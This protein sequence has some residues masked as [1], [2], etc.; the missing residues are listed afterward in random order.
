MS[1]LADEPVEDAP[2]TRIPVATD[3]LVCSGVS[4]A[5]AGVRALDQVNFSGP[6][7]PVRRPF[8]TCSP[9]SRE[10]SQARSIST[11]VTS[12][13]LLRIDGHGSDWKGHSSTGVSSRD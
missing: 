11:D 7:V 13:A 2:A 9:V 5:F 12:L 10:L 6:T 8:S 4:V 3:R 1:H